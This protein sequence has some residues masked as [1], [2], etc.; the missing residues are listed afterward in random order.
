MN[1]IDKAVSSDITLGQLL[2]GPMVAPEA[3]LAFLYEGHPVKA[4]YHIT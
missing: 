3:P 4:G 2:D 1:I